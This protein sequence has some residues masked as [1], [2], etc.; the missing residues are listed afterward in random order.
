[1]ARA[2]SELKSSAKKQVHKMAKAKVNLSN[3][4]AKSIMVSLPK[5]KNMESMKTD[6]MLSKKAP[7]RIGFVDG[8]TL[9]QAMD[10]DEMLEASE[11]TQLALKGE[12]IPAAESP[13]VQNYVNTVLRL[14]KR[15]SRGLQIADKLQRALIAR[16]ID[17]NR[18]TVDVEKGKRLHYELM[19]KE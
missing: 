2:K 12:K 18:K 9:I 5:P 14:N 7:I 4:G 10:L 19:E 6:I 11:A 13:K 17:I 8:Y 16:I 3:R 1:M 15:G